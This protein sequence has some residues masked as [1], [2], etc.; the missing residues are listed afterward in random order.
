M[1]KYC[2]LRN[3]D[4]IN[5]NKRFYNQKTIITIRT[6]IIPTT[7]KHFGNPTTVVLHQDYDVCSCNRQPFK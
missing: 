7:P 1:P 2:E 5:I 6:F 3:I 4:F